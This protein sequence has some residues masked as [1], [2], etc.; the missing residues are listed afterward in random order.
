MLQ[1]TTRKPA[2][3]LL[4]AALL[5]TSALSAQTDY[6]CSAEK[7]CQ[8]VNGTDGCHVVDGVLTDQIT[9]TCRTS[10]KSF[11]L[12]AKRRTVSLK[13]DSLSVTLK[14]ARPFFSDVNWYQSGATGERGLLNFS[15]DNEANKPTFVLREMAAGSVNRH[16][17]TLSGHCEVLN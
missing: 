3:A 2:Q 17:W 14:E 1:I 5:P 9:D 15:F 10:S 16:I 4:A 11:A 8:C 12:E 13:G 6:L 7:F